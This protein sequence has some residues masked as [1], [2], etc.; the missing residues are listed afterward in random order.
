M[1]FWRTNRARYVQVMVFSLVLDHK[2]AHAKIHKLTIRSI[3]ILVYVK[4]TIIKTQQMHAYC[5]ETI[6]VLFKINS[7]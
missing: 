4:L 1:G 2:F 6:K 5:V 7:A 3:I